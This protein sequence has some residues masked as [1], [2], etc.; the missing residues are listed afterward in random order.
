MSKKK[1]ELHISQENAQ[2]TIII[3][4]NRIAELGAHSCHLN[5]SLIRIQ[6]LFDMIRNLPSD[7]EKKFKEL[8][9]VRLAWLQHVESISDN[10]KDTINKEKASGT[11]GATLGVGVAALGPSVMMGVATTFGVA[12]TGTAISSLSGAVATK[13]ALAWLGGGALSAGGGGIAAGQA[14]IALSGPIGWAIAGTAIIASGVMYLITK[15]DNKRLENVY[16]L[17]SERDIKKYQAA[18]ADIDNR[19]KRMV[20][21]SSE[22][23]NA[24]MEVIQFGTDYSKM[25]KDQKLQLGTYL[26]FMLSATQ[27]LTVPI[28]D[29]QLSYPEEELEKFVKVHTIYGSSKN[30]VVKEKTKMKKL[31]ES[32][33]VDQYDYL[34]KHR[35]IVLSLCNLLYSIPLD[36][37]DRRLLCDSFRKNKVFLEQS[38][39]EKD[40]IRVDLFM[41]IK[42]MLDFQ[43]GQ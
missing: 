30:E 38:K 25:S 15:S 40:T 4:N 5:E 35:P 26:N 37:K 23:N 20:K 32:D 43:N 21:E 11:A 22:L 6:S 18:I 29:L 42:K 9:K 2:S 19:V 3:L 39:I 10:Y 12:S 17:I 27:L 1:S 7:E 33:V 28:K 41:L 14:L 13:A 31:G 16:R 34:T 36:D 8:E 24:S